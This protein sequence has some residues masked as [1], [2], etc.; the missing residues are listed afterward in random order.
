MS[1]AGPHCALRW[2]F[3]GCGNISNDFVNALKSVD[4]AVLHACAA[5]SLPSAEEFAATHGFA[6]AY[7]SYEE[8]VADA[9]VDV[10]YIGTLHI[11][12]YEHT[13]LSLNHGKHVLVEKPM[14]MNTKQA[15][16]AV[17]LAKE[18]KLFLMEGMW[19]RFF[20]A[21]QHVRKVLASNEIGDVHHVNA[22]IGYPFPPNYQRMWDRA[23]GGGGLLDIGIYPLAFVTM[24]FGGEPQKISAVGKLSDGGVDIYSSV[25]LEFSGF[26]FGTIEYTCLAQMGE[27]VTIIGSKGR[28]HIHSPAHVP[29]EITVVKYG[30]NGANNTEQSFKFPA[31]EPAANATPNC[32]G[33]GTTSFVYEA[34]AVTNAILSGAFECTEYPVSES[35]ALMGIMDKIRTDLGVV[36]DADT[37]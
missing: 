29:T 16:H 9:S 19:T 3:I 21:V 10:V 34:Q 7:G 1:T 23:L 6:H 37:N 33:D 30:E 14:A 12:H 18:K 35:L 8:L 24:I 31:P 4:N 20:P 32:F 22:D 17:A 13:V 26:R 2:G 25:T 15:A 28:V 36:Y 27:T 5:R 11:S